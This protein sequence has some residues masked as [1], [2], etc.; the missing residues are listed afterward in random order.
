MWIT[1]DANPSCRSAVAASAVITPRVEMAAQRRSCEVTAVVTVG[2]VAEGGG[3][4]SHPARRAALSL[5]LPVG[6]KRCAAAR[7]RQTSS[8]R[9]KSRYAIGSTT[10]PNPAWSN[11][12]EERVRPPGWVEPGLA[13]D[14]SI[15]HA[16]AERA[17]PRPM[18]RC[19]GVPPVHGGLADT[20]DVHNRSM[21]STTTS[22]PARPRRAG[23]H[24]G[25]WF[26]L[27]SIA[28]GGPGCAGILGY[29]GGSRALPSGCLRV[30]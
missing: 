15:C 7:V 8:R 3:L 4:A 20:T 1:V 25:V 11:S 19:P 24:C 21:T 26:R 27:I 6:A 13:R 18:L 14:R 29:C 2:T 17:R 23:A 12:V 28:T 10:R 30:P 5:D 16:E 9:C 22:C